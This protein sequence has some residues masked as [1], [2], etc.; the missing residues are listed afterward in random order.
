MK[1]VTIS[2]LKQV[3]AKEIRD[4]GCFELTSDGEV[5]AIVIVGAESLMKDKIRAA[6]SQIDAMR[7]K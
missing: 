1:Q 6:A 4:G 3:T 5:V 7:G 2:K